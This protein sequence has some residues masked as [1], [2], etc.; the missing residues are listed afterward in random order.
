MDWLGRLAP[1]GIGTVLVMTA[2]GV[3]VMVLAGLLTRGRSG[4]DRLLAR[5]AGAVV[6]FGLSQVVPPRLPTSWRGAHGGEPAS[7]GL[8][9]AMFEQ[10][11]AYRT[12]ARREPELWRA[13]LDRA[14][15][16]AQAAEASGVPPPAAAMQAAFGPL[17]LRLAT[18]AADAGDDAVLRWAGAEQALNAS[19][20]DKDAALCGARV[21]G[22]GFRTDLLDAGDAA[23]WAAAQDAKVSAYEDGVQTPSPAPRLDAAAGAAQLGR[24]VALPGYA[25][26]PEEAGAL[27]DLAAA[28]PALACRAWTHLNRNILVLPRPDAA[29]LA[30]F[31]LGPPPG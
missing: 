23:L 11:P 26:P 29:A 2:L 17:L 25:L 10:V 12:L 3:L 8:E 1:G 14:S 21:L 9:A 24:V 19:L 27:G 13:A 18:V 5:V 4:R 31:V 16:M 20:L 7:A 15:P 30:R 28:G 6:I 22:A